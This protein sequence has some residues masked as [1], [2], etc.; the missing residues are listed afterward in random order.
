MLRRERTTAS[1][2]G[3]ARDLEMAAVL[4]VAALAF[5][6]PTARRDRGTVAADRS[7][8]GVLRVQD[9]PEGILSD[10]RVLRVGR[11]FHGGQFLDPARA[12]E[13]TAYFTAGSGVEIAIRRHPKQSSPRVRRTHSLRP[14]PSFR[15]PIP[16]HRR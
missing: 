4:V 5:A 16:H 1:G 13:A 9:R 8:Y 11:I 14:I 3:A 15:W 7:F 12:Q 6:V 10:E 2:G